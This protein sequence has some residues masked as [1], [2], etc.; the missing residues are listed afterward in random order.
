MVGRK[1][2][3]ED[4]ELP[5]ETDEHSEDE[6]ENECE[7]EEE[8]KLD[9]WEMD[10]E[11]E[12]EKE[13]SDAEEDEYDADSEKQGT[14]AAAKDFGKKKCSLEKPQHLTQFNKDGKIKIISNMGINNQLIKHN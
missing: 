9:E 3:M 11:E 1:E 6:D 13:N 8:L 12:K 2:S 7:N 5:M 10:E 4:E 14:S